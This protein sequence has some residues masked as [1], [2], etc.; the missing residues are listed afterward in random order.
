MNQRIGSVASS[1]STAF[2]SAPDRITAFYMVAVFGDVATACSFAS[3]VG[4]SHVEWLYGAVW[5]KLNRPTHFYGLTF[6]T[7]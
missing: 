7:P 4:V 6:Q 1:A 2:V 3:E 5:A